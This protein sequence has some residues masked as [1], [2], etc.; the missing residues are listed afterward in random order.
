[1]AALADSTSTTT[2]KVD[3]KAQ[4]KP[5]PEKPDEEAF[6]ANLANAEK[7]HAITQEKLVRA[8]TIIDCLK[9]CLAN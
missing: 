8:Q 1:M 4:P 7:E 2:P 9:L 6:K 3:A 5:I